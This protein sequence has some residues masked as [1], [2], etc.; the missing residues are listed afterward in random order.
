MTGERAATSEA[1]V[2]ITASR[3]K[4][5]CLRCK[6]SNRTRLK[7]DLIAGFAHDA[8]DISLEVPMVTGTTYDVTLPSCL[9]PDAYISGPWY[10]QGK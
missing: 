2:R 6:R 1:R 7:Q 3:I 8:T 9:L 4:A 5:Y 10:V